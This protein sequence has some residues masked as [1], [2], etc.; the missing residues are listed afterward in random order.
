MSYCYSL[1]THRRIVL[2]KQ[3]YVKVDVHLPRKVVLV[4]DCIIQ[5][6]RGRSYR[7]VIGKIQD[8]II[9]DKIQCLCEWIEIKK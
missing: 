9:Q 2:S 6:V 4:V 5:E 1:N 3:D 8:V 7:T